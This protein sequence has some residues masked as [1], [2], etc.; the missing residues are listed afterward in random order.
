MQVRAIVGAAAA[1]E[2]RAATAPLV[3]IMHPLV[4]FREELRAAPRAD[5]PVAGEEGELDYLAAP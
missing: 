5:R 2:A 1:V 3:E 4:G